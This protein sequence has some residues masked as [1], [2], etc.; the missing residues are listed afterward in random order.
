M[1]IS[2]TS[3]ESNT[4]PPS[5]CP[6]PTASVPVPIPDHTTTYSSLLP[7][8]PILDHTATYSSPLPTVPKL[9]NRNGLK[10]DSNYRERERD[11]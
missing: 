5:Q 10:M 1:V 3:H 9:L 4:I 2:P 7:T 6:L 8:A 11:D